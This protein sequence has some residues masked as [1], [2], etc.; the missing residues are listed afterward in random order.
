MEFGGCGATD[1]LTGEPGGN[2]GDWAGG[3][4]LT[5]NIGSGG[6]PGRAIAGSGYSITGTINTNT[7]K[8]LY[9]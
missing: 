8:G 2:G 1:G 3:G 4:G 7:I 6:S 5:N 9:Q